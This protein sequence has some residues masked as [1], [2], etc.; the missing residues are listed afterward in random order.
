MKPALHHIFCSCCEAFEIRRLHSSQVMYSFT[1]GFNIYAESR[2]KSDSSRFLIFYCFPPPTVVKSPPVILIIIVHCT[3]RL[4]SALPYYF[5]P[6]IPPDSALKLTLFSADMEEEQRVLKCVLVGDAEVGKTALA[7][8]YS[9]NGFPQI[10]TPTA[11]DNY[12]G[13]WL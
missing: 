4:F 13:E 10:Y 8:A 11:Y 7:V 9:T 12:S 5:V 1:I 3:F 6:H 2:R